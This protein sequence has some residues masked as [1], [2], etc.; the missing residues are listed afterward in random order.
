MFG[1]LISKRGLQTDVDSEA[2]GR[3]KKEGM[4]GK[5]GRAAARGE[6][7]NDCWS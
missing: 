5:V 6:A 1:V 7:H 2:G 3:E 4:K